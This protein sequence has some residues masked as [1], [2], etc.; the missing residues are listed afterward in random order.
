MPLAKMAATYLSPEDINIDIGLLR[1]QSVSVLQQMPSYRK[2]VR[3]ADYQDIGLDDALGLSPF[4]RMAG[5]TGSSGPLVVW[6]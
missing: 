6:L 5:A 4:H 2:P 1:R 3:P